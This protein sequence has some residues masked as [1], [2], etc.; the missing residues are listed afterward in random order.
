MS[1][2]TA[3]QDT[4]TIHIVKELEIDAPV[5][6]AYEAL[7]EELGSAFETGEGKAL[8]MAIEPWPGGRWYRDLG[9]KIGH[10]W[11]HVQVIKPPVLVELCGPMFMSYPALN[12]VQYRLTADGGRT[13]L[14]FTHRA[15]GLIPQD[16]QEGVVHGWEFLLD[17]LKQMAERK[18]AEQDKKAKR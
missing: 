2:K 7:L 6:I 16:H 9:D 13:K 14:T 4:A 18:R 8:Q 10:L 5:E 15:L 1:L 3:D 12:H 17:K 11:G